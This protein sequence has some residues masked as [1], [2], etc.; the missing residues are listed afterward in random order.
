M[1][2]MSKSIVQ[3]GQSVPSQEAFSS[4][5]KP[6]GYAGENEAGKEVPVHGPSGVPEIF[7]TFHV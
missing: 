6:P 1:L 5:L 7:V 3:V 2:P 4:T